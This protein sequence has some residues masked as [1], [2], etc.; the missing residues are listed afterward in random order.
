[1]ALRNL[2]ERRKE[3]R[4]KKGGKKG[5]KKKGGPR[6]KHLKRVELVNLYDFL[7]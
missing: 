5:G 2:E 1:V 3:R 7:F 4:E 6:R